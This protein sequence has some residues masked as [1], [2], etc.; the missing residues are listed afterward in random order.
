MKLKKASIKM[1]PE[2]AKTL[3]PLFSYASKKFR[4]FSIL[5]QFTGFSDGTMEFEAV[6]LPED[7]SNQITAIVESW[8][9]G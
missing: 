1:T 5:G 6:A 8:K 3:D 9:E 4:N 2:Q 7:V